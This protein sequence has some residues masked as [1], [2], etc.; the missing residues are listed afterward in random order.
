[1]SKTKSTLIDKELNK[2]ID[3]LADRR[4]DLEKQ[5]KVLAENVVDA[6]RD[7]IRGSEYIEAARWHQYTPGFNDGDPCE[8]T[9]NDLEVKFSEDLLSEY[10]NKEK[11]TDKKKDEDEDEEEEDDVDEDDGWVDSYEVESF[12]KEKIDVLNH[13]EIGLL[14]KQYEAACKLHGV[15]SSM[16][17]ALLDKFGDNIQI[18]VT[19]KGI[20]TEDYDCGY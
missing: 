19:K 10:G 9:V 18:T 7:I 2:R 20:E 12:L 3:E 16:E 17:G 11:S 5:E 1:M 8:F 6:L 14:E 4:K 13:K 15:L